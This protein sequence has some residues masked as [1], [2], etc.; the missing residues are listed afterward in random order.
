MF[1][2]N[3]K[4]HAFP[5][6][7]VFIGATIVAALGVIVV[8]GIMVKKAVDASKVPSKTQLKITPQSAVTQLT[9]TKTA[10]LSNNLSQ[11]SA[12]PP[13]LYPGQR[14]I[15]HPFRTHPYYGP[16][17]HGIIYEGRNFD[18]QYITH[19]PCAGRLVVRLPDGSIFV[20][21]GRFVPIVGSVDA[22][23]FVSDFPCQPIS[24]IVDYFHGTLAVIIR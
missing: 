13:P 22:W 5:N 8:V 6:N 18:M 4:D 23:R 12:F 19:G 16:E 20:M 7:N 24:V 9:N 10:L 11:A 1:A 2:I 15:S 17:G 14:F 3:N 21:R